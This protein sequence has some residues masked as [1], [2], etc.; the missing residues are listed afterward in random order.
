MI[1]LDKKIRLLEPFQTMVILFLACLASFFHFYIFKNTNMNVIDEM[2]YMM[3]ILGESKDSAY[4]SPLFFFLNKH[5]TI[6]NNIV[7]NARFL[8]LIFYLLGLI[9]IY[10]IA[11][12]YLDI[13]SSFLIVVFYLFSPFSQ[14]MSNIMPEII[15]GTFFYWALYVLDKAHFKPNFIL[16]CILTL[17]EILLIYTK[18]HGIF[19][20]PVIALSMFLG[21]SDIQK[22][23]TTPALFVLAVLVV[24]F[25]IDSYIN[26]NTFIFGGV[27][28]GIYRSNSYFSSDIFL[29]FII[30]FSGHFLYIITFLTPIFLL[31]LFKKNKI[32]L[33]LQREIFILFIHL[34]TMF[35][36][37]ISSYY[38]AFK[39]DEI[40]TI[41]HE[42]YYA[43]L[44]TPILITYLALL[45]K[46]DFAKIEYK[47]FVAISALLIII[48][49][50]LLPHYY[51]LSYIDNTNMNSFLSSKFLLIG[52]VFILLMNYFRILKFHFGLILILIVFAI[53]ISP[54]GYISRKN[55]TPPDA[56]GKFVCNNNLSVNNIYVDNFVSFGF[57]YYHCP[58]K[59][60][61]NFFNNFDFKF[62]PHSIYI[63]SFVY[64]NPEKFQQLTKISDSIFYKK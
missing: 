15:F 26:S 35:L 2:Q 33:F 55:N 27:Y 56:A 44:F 9:P 58:G 43:F 16:F 30:N 10:K 46:I 49:G 1:S 53:F 54:L 51:Q 39:S 38:M 25:I 40:I 36:I 11:K 62:K 47:Y 52:L 59:Y 14:Y 28:E 23:F 5:I 18:N 21:E 7:E 41:L 32:K 37:V 45:S 13:T 50:T 3:G 48:A 63:G 22:K 29:R 60:N 34:L 31:I 24:K 4:P 42:R 57:F 12:K 61:V 17:L 20:L 19:I 64:Q 6:S 8:N